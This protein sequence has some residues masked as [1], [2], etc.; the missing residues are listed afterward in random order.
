MSYYSFIIII[1][2]IIIIIARSVS[3]I[4]KSRPSLSLRYFYRYFFQVERN[5]RIIKLCGNE[6]RYKFVCT[7]YFLANEFMLENL[8][9]FLVR[10]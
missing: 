4:T 10:R 6:K 7:E 3:D 2:I 5:D 1:I 8:E 9:L